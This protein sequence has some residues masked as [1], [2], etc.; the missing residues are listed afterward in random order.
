MSSFNLHLQILNL[1]RVNMRTFNSNVDLPSVSATTDGPRR[2][3]DAIIS[4]DLCLQ[5]VRN[6]A[7]YRQPQLAEE[8]ADI[9]QSN[10][11]RTNFSS[12]IWRL[13]TEILSEIFLY[14]LPEDEY[15]VYAATQAP[16]LLTRICR[17]WR[18]I[19]VDLP[20]LWCR[21]QLEFWYEDWQERA[22]RHDD[23]QT[24]AFGYDSWLKRSRGYPLSLRLECGT[25]WSEL[26][27]LLQP[28]VQQISSLSLGFLSCD[29]PFMMEDFHALKELTICKYIFDD[30]ARAI[31][32]SLS[33]LPVNLRRINMENVW[34]NRKRLNFFTH[35][36]WARLTHIEINLD[37]LCAFTRI[38]HLCPDLSSLKMTGI[39]CTRFKLCKSVTHTNLQSLSMSWSVLRN[40]GEGLGL[41]KVITLPNLRMLEVI[42]RGPWPHESFMKFLTRSKCPLERLR[43]EYAALIPSNQFLMEMNQQDVQYI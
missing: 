36:A 5:L 15:L 10:T 37:G 6:S 34:F 32:R 12:P 19:A 28:Y 9:V 1:L 31:N 29:G 38:L 35:S 30:P 22:F 16:M 24:R 25:D 43:E 4:E 13:P 27:S 14:C 17:R 26:Q 11:S 7:G 42:H 3:S 40:S 33:K 39:F 21:L 20:V 2:P 8:K 23:W 18:E 41:F